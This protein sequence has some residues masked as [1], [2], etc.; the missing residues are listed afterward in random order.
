[1]SASK[2]FIVGI[3]GTTK[4]NSSAEQAL[5]LA[6]KHAAAK[7][8]ETRIFTGHDLDFPAYD[9]ETAAQCA[10]A[11]AMI[12]ALRRADGVIFASPC[13]HGA[14]SG[15]VKNAIDYTE[16]MRA[17]PRVYLDGRAIG[18]IGLGYGFQGPVAIITQLRSIAHA[19]R[20]WPTPLGVAI[21]SAVVKFGNGECS[22]PAIAQQI[23]IMAGQ[24]VDF[25]TMQKR[26]A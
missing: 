24:V 3:G 26:N 22:E 2:P 11:Q 15:L 20:G 23:A 10:P 12:E 1:M 19:L 9:P 18:V 4:L 5:T 14:I 17:D 21:N 13:Y 25:A 8:A 6:L 7:G 16:D